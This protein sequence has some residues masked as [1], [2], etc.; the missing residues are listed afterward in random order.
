MAVYLKK[1]S[2]YL[3]EQLWT[4]FKEAVLMRHGTLRKLSSEGEN[5]LQTLI[6]DENIENAFKKMNINMRVVFSPEEMKRGRPEPQGP[7]SESLIRGIREKRVA[8]DLP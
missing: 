3:D 5:L 8:K 6:S 2:L 4:R 1:V 7:P